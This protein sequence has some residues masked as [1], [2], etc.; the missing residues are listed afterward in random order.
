MGG[1]LFVSLQLRFGKIEDSDVRSE[2]REGC[3]L[4][5]AATGETERCFAC[6]IPQQ[7]LRIQKLRADSGVRSK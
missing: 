4:L 6:H 1:C 7:T 5:P 2:Q 3:R